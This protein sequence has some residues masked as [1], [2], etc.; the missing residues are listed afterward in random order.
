MKNRNMHTH[1]V[2]TA[3]CSVGVFTLGFAASSALAGDSSGFVSVSNYRQTTDSPFISNTLVVDAFEAG[4]SVTGITI[5]GQSLVTLG[6]SVDDDDSVLDGNGDTRNSLALGSWGPF[7]PGSATFVYS[8]EIL[9]G[10]PTQVG[11]VVTDLVVDSKAGQPMASPVTLQ[12]ILSDGSEVHLE[13]S[14]LSMPGNALDDRFIGYSNS[15][16]IASMSVLVEVPI[17]VDHLQFALPPQL[18]SPAV[19]DDFDGDGKSDVAWFNKL[20]RGGAIWHVDGTAVT[21]DYTSINSSSNTA[22]LIATAD[23]DADG[24]ADMLWYDPITKRYSIWLMNGYAAS[25]TLIDRYVGSDW[26]PAGYFDINSDRNADVIFFR[27]ANGQTQI[28]VWLMSGATI[29]SAQLNTLPGVWDNMFV[30]N[31]D[32]DSDGEALLRESHF[33]DNRDAVYVANFTGSSISTPTRITNLLGAVEPVMAPGSYIAGLADI[34]G[35]GMSDMLWRDS[36]GSIESW[37]IKNSSIQSKRV[38]S[39]NASHYWT[40]TSF[41]DFDGDGTQGVF[42]RGGA[43]ETWSWRMEAGLITESNPLNTVIPSWRTVVMPHSQIQ[44]S[45]SM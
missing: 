11:V 23:A 24:K 25:A 4:P 2:G 18:L 34:T 12:C 31:M 6:N 19:N 20:S 27:V 13:Y 41:P 43:G 44:Y 39:P 5:L 16:G 32:P 30:G 15:L 29:A 17:S 26:T 9:G 37:E 35:D 28:A 45:L 3:V 14:I 42:F 36:T 33:G 8:A 38:L 7:V 40:I 1:L 21:G 22:V 10:L